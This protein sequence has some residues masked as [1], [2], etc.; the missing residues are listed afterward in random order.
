MIG[1]IQQTTELSRAAP[2]VA[3]TAVAVTFP[4]QTFPRPRR[5]RPWRLPDG[6]EGGRSPAGG[7]VQPF[8]AQWENL[9]FTRGR[10]M[11]TRRGALWVL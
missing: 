8:T 6:H 10:T 9:S 3:I 2:G 7:Q 11:H 5:G 1:Y 4:G